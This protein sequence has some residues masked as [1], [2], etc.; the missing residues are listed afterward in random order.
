MPGFLQ[1]DTFQLIDFF[2]WE[3]DPYHLRGKQNMRLIKHFFNADLKT[4]PLLLPCNLPSPKELPLLK[5]TYDRVLK[6]MVL[7]GW[8]EGW[9][10]PTACPPLGR[11]QAEG[12][13]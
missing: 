8:T 5:E 12:S 10:V 6:E 3:I 9:M 11:P 7:G 1:K 2:L 13:G 4:H